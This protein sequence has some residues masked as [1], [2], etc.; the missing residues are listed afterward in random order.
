MSGA[1]AEGI[2]VAEEDRARADL[3]ALFARL[4]HSGPDERLL[5]AFVIAPE[6]EGE[7][8][9][10]RAWAALAQAAAAT[11]PQLA[12]LEYDTVFVGTGKAEVTPYASWYLVE[13][14]RERVR[15]RLKDELATLGLERASAEPEDHVATLLEVM[16]HLILTSGRTRDSEDAALRQQA[17]FFD[18]YL[19]RSYPGFVEAIENC[20]QARFYKAVSRCAKAFLDVETA[21][22]KMSN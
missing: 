10:H 5:H 1:D 15:V 22:L 8:E 19:A 3:Y 4:F 9:F 7:G 12:T 2:T 20:S 21:A 17:D 14:G 18:R 6:P 13:T 16:R 11:D